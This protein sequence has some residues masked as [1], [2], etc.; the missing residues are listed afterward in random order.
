MEYDCVEVCDGAEQVPVGGE[1][2]AG[3]RTAR[4]K[5]PSPAEL[6]SV[7]EASEQVAP[8]KNI[9]CV[10]IKAA[11]F[12]M[13]LREAFNKIFRGGKTRFDMCKKMIFLILP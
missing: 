6:P 12:N 13:A 8:G 10:G 11:K 3:L 2:A 7:L 4:L 5:E 1:E 9:L